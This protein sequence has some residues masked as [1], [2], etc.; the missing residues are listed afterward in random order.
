MAFVGGLSV[1]GGN[2]RGFEVSD[3]ICSA[4]GLGDGKVVTGGKS[5]RVEV[6]LGMSESG[7]A[8]GSESGACPGCGREEGSMKGCDGTGRIGGGISALIEWWPI[9]AYRPCDEYLKRKGEYKRSGQSLE[10]IAFGKKE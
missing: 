3:R 6:V 10:E 7:A 5:V 2:R 9:K 4:G 1:G 8:S